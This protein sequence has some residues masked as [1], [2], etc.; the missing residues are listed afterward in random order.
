M[1]RSDNDSAIT[2]TTNDAETMPSRRRPGRLNDVH[3]SLI[4]LLR[5]SVSVDAG[6][7]DPV[8]LEDLETTADNLAPARGI[9][10]AIALSLP[11]WAL[12]IRSVY[13]LLH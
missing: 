8:L 10:V 3:P 1:S 2:S 9:M 6:E 12:L 4:P 11:V 5:G 13:L 7:P